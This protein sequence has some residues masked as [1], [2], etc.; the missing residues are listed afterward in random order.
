M[1][2]IPGPHFTAFTS[3]ARIVA[4]EI[5]NAR[6]VFY[7]YQAIEQPPATLTND[8]PPGKMKHIETMIDELQ[9]ELK[10]YCHHFKI[11]PESRGLRRELQTKFSFLWDELAG[12]AG[13][14]LHGYGA[15]EEELKNDFE[16]RIRRMKAIVEN[17]IEA[18]E[19]DD[20]HVLLK[21]NK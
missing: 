20:D 6:A 15:I 11:A 12:A 1:H 2:K 5:M 3:I 16:N 9:S 17:I 18:C 7:K 13:S 14:R 4:D 19:T 21:R 8:L 10:N